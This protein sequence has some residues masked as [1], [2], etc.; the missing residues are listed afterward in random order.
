M[1]LNSPT[2]RK[3]V[4]VYL[5]GKI[6]KSDWRHKI[7]PAL[8]DAVPYDL[9]VRA[10]MYQME[11]VDGFSFVGPCFVSCDHGCGH[12]DST[13]GWGLT[14]KGCFDKSPYLRSETRRLL[15]SET[16]LRGINRASYVFCW[17]EVSAPSGLCSSWVTPA[18][19]GNEPLS[20]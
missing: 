14:G 17:I 8:R 4:N 16:C 18:R 9:G 12:G 6:G 19:N 7:F 13:H 11:P 5:A 1:E 2:R 15:V 20:G 3:P 10:Q